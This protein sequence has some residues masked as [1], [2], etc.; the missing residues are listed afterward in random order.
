VSDF[1]E[2]ILPEMIP[3]GPPQDEGMPVAHAPAPTQVRALRL[4]HYLWMAGTVLVIAAL[5]HWLGPILTP[6]LVGGILAY[7]GKPAVSW[8]EKKRVPR[9]VGALLVMLVALVLALI[10]ALAA[11]Y[12]GMLKRPNA[13]LVLGTV[14]LEGLFVFGG[15]SYLASSLTDRFSI[16]YAYAGLMVA[17]FG[18]GGLVYSFSVKRLVGRIGELGTLLL[19]G[20]LLGVA[21]VA[22]AFRPLAHL[23]LPHFLE[24]LQVEDRRRAGLA[25][26]REAAVEIGRERDAVHAGG[27]RDVARDLARR[28]V[29]H[30]HVRRARDE[31][32]RALRLGD[33]IVP[34]A[35][36]AE[37]EGLHDVIAGG[38]GLGRRGRGRGLRLDRGGGG[39]Q[40][41]QE[42]LHGHDVSAAPSN[43][44]PSE[45][46][47]RLR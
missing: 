3:S 21:F 33:E 10:Y 43:R 39:E 15:L 36:A 8:M 27:V 40:D 31:Q 41:G 47:F 44:T 35:L 32:V 4:P 18:V 23:H 34:A 22:I 14:L 6:F 46:N 19:G 13:P 5:L 30:H 9:T 16:N 45:G 2:S 38:R 1:F 28:R 20:T 37:L 7:V 17:G 24:R 26:A 11:Q 42:D 12:G 25:V 29:D